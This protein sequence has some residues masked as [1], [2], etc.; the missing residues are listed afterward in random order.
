MKFTP[1][2]KRTLWEIKLLSFLNQEN[3]IQILDLFPAIEMKCIES[4]YMVSELMSSDLMQVIHSNS[5][6]TDDHIKYILF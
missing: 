5:P 2:L 1:I 4:I 3:I 6:L